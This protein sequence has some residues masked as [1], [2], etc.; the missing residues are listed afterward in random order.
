MRGTGQKCLC[1]ILPQVFCLAQPS[2]CQW[3]SRMV[4]SV[5][6]TANTSWTLEIPNLRTFKV[7]L[8]SSSWELP[9]QP[10]KVLNY[11]FGISYFW[12]FLVLSEFAALIGFPIYCCGFGSC[13]THSWCWFVRL[14]EDDK[15][16][17]VKP[18]N[19]PCCDDIGFYCR[20]RF[21]AKY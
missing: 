20:R 15:V 3:I 7:P 17:M 13:D 16:D 1:D 4:Y 19:P 8:L 10:Q 6:I 18:S 2:T 9:D 11:I 14:D 21:W 5:K 12:Y